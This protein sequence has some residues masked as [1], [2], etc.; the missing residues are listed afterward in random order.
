[1]ALATGL[2]VTLGGP[3]GQALAQRLRGGRPEPKEGLTTG[4]MTAE[5]VA[6]LEERIAE[7]EGERSSLEERLEFAERLLIRGQHDVPTG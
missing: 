3:I 2:A 4:E 6:A 5:R 1:M 7:L